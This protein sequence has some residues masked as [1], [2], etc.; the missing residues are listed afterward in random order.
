MYVSPCAAHYYR[1]RFF[2]GLGPAELAE[3][4]RILQESLLAVEE[5]QAELVAAPGSEMARL[6]GE[7]ER[8]TMELRA[9][10]A[11]VEEL[12]GES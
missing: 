6:R 3:Q 7:L 12:L 4:R 11:A 8:E 2:E 10:L 5:E 9:K 1:Q